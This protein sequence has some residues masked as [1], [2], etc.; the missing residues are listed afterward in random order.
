MFPLES[1]IPTLPVPLLLSTTQ[2]VLSA[3]KPLLT[4]EEYADVVDQAGQFVT[5]ETITLVQQHLEAAAKNKN[6]ACY[7]SA[8]NG[9]TYPGV[10]GTIRGDTLPRNPY[11]VLEEDPYAMTINPPNQ[12]QRAASLI[13]SS[14]K[15]I[16]SMRNGTLKP[17]VTPKSGKP[18]T[19]NC[20][21]NL[22]GTTRVPDQ[23]DEFSGKH[24]TIQK[25]DNYDDSRHVLF[26]CNNQFYTVEVLTPGPQPHQIWFNDA[27]LAEIIQQIIDTASLVDRIS[28]VSNG[29]G[30]ITTQTFDTWKSARA[31][32]RKSNPR[33]LKAIDDA[34]FVVALD[35][36]NLPTSDQDKTM[37]ILHGTSTML[38][39]T[40]IQIGSCTSRWYDK[41]QLVVTANAVAG[42]VWELS[43]MDLTAILRFISDIYTD[44]I[45]KLARNINGAESTLF[46]SSI[47]FV[48]GKDR[49]P[50]PRLLAFNKTPELLNL[51]HLSET[52]LAD[53]L[54]QH[55]YRTL[56]MKIDTHLL[57][58]LGLLADSFLQ[59][60]FQIANYA[61]YGR[62]ANTLEPITTRKFRDARTDLIAVQ[63]DYIASLVKLYISSLDDSRKWLAFKACAAAHTEQYRA[64]MAGQGF[65]RHLT[66][67]LDVLR[68][69]AAARNLNRVN[70][71]SGLPKLPEEPI[72]EHVPLLSMPVIDKLSSAEL[73]IS[74]CGNPA[75]RLFGIP[76]AIDQGFGIGYIIHKDR[77]VVTIASK[78]RQTERF[79]G[80]FHSVMSAIKHIARSKLDVTVAAADS[81]VRKTELHRLRIEKELLNL[82]KNLLLTRH[83]IDISLGTS[84][85]SVE[86]LTAKRT[87]SEEM[88]EEDYNYLGGYGYFD[89]GE[90]G[91]R[92]EEL[93]R[94]ESFLNSSSN[95]TLTHGSR[96]GSRHHSST[97][98]KHMGRNEADVRHKMSITELIRDRMASPDNAES[99]EF[100]ETV[101]DKPRSQ[102]GRGLTLGS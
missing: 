49:K 10:Y 65:E 40:N 66:A 53:L 79:L 71:A 15:F 42:V 52:R 73:L 58:S 37:V 60:G 34:L 55:E 50:D 96:L 61:L 102:I 26:I 16:V 54:H 35:T 20:Y 8:V 1:R 17:D 51:V 95:L 98:L 41:L 13:N 7:L 84:G 38:E 78:H 93:S 19:M 74:N 80:T 86:N 64:A 91:L 89:V 30:A 57:T 12:A 88:T 85:S 81:D 23:P 32:M 36:V 27:E 45:L 82:N 29:I 99:V 56:S 4:A 63:N 67:I 47:T 18:L 70:A 62:L 44:S 2:Q 28:S 25:Y 72:H 6:V 48:S 31:E 3:L 43:S 59:I 100:E 92:N 33:S 83:P 22:F 21:K 76:P 77:V 14:L 68:K 24:V 97:N 94:N 9:E 5:N 46:D 39:G 101:V 87:D 11:L 90:V 75:L 69:P